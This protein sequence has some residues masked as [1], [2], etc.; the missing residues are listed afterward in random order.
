MIVMVTVGSVV[1]VRDCTV[2]KK[3]SP[4]C[5]PKGKNHTYDRDPNTAVVARVNL[6]HWS[7]DCWAKSKYAASSPTNV[8]E[9]LLLLLL[10]LRSSSG[11]VDIAS[12]GSGGDLVFIVIIIAIVVMSL[13]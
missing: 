1:A 5:H 3:T 13:E 6:V 4:P 12:T 10:L 2:F 11:I 9:S 8:F 7:N